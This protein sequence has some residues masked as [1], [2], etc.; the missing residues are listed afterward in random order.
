MSIERIQQM[1]YD[2][3]P[4]DGCHSRY[5]FKVERDKQNDSR[6][7][8]VFDPSDSEWDYNTR[9]KTAA[10]LIDDGNGIKVVFDIPNEVEGGKTKVT[11][12]YSQV[13]EMYMLLDYFIHYSGIVDSH[14][15]NPPIINKSR[16]VEG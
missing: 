13:Y 16:P 8:M 14:L 3:D 7:R 12:D 11:L 2:L 15:P 10:R 6:V 4:G 5:Q 9:G 1:T